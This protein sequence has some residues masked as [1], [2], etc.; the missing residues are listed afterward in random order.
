ML[1]I[2]NALMILLKL[3]PLATHLDS[4]PSAAVLLSGFYVDNWLMSLCREC[5][6]KL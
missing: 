5:N 2:K 4:D 1:K 3:E 6:F